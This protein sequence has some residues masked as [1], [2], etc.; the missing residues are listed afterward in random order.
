[1]L[2]PITWMSV[3]MSIMMLA[4]AAEPQPEGPPITPKRVEADSN[5]DGKIDRTVYYRAD[6]TAERAERDNDANGQ[7]DEWIYFN[8][9]GDVTKGERDTDGDGKA[10]TWMYY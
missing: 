5:K 10:D 3:T 8:E 1:M 6:G 2:R 9:K 7:I 4:T